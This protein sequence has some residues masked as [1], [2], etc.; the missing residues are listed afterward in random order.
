M[1]DH[2]KDRAKG[3]PG[4]GPDAPAPADS[5]DCDNGEAGLRRLARG[6]IYRTP[7]VRP[8]KVARL[9][10]AIAQGAYEI[11]AGSLADSII[12]ELIRKR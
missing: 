5:G 11:D 1:S 10:E 9:K 4:S 7:E 12:A 3:P 8:E 6:I 2:P